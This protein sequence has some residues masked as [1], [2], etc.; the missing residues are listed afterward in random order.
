MK[1]EK[2]VLL[3]PSAF[4]LHPSGEAGMAALEATVFSFVP[5]DDRRTLQLFVTSLCL[6]AAL[7]VAALVV[8]LVKRWRRRREAE[9]DLSPNAQLAHFRSLYEAG[10]ISQDEFERLRAVLGARMRETLGLPRKA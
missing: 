8:A 4:F 5:L 3:H 2:T 1:D 10:T 7:L 6:V 9:E